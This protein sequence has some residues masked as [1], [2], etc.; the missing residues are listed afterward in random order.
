MSNMGKV[1]TK[2]IV[3]KAPSG[4]DDLHCADGE[5]EGGAFIFDEAH[6]R[7]LPDEATALNPTRI[8]RIGSWLCLLAEGRLHFARWNGKT[9]DWFGEATAPPVAHF[10][11]G[12]RALPPFSAMAGEMPQISIQAPTGSD[13]PKDVL[14]WL[15]SGADTCSAA[16]RQNV[17]NAVRTRLK[18]FLTEV[19]KAG[20]HFYPVKAAAARRLADGT[21]FQLSE[22]AI[23][24]PPG[25]TE[26]LSLNI[27][28]AGGAD[29]TV[30]LNLELSRSPFAVEAEIDEEN[31]LP[32][33]IS[34]TEILT[35]GEWVDFTPDAITYPVW[36]DGATR[37]FSITVSAADS[38]S[39]APFPD[40]DDYPAVTPGEMEESADSLQPI[41][42]RPL[43]L[44]NPFETKKLQEIEAIW[45][46][47]SRLPVKVYGAARLGKWYFLGLAP[48]GRMLMLGSGWRFFR[49]QTFAVFNGTRYLLPKLILSIK[50][51][52]SAR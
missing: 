10:T 15:A 26:T 17:I 32:P 50:R 16:T 3:M 52:E 20:L 8:K 29:G 42:T 47:G 48:H 45:A 18:E 24:M 46:D 37:G 25:Y 44:G 51:E 40:A 49:V 39:F 12:A 31:G 38:D 14:D 11:A 33:I 13:T 2:T 21:L 19:R 5:L 23:V 43:K 36:T 7:P 27:R 4:N 9:Y 34:R 22:P 6:S 35:A 28:S 41:T 30:Y 1:M